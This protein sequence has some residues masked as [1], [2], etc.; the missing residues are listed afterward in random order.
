MAHVGFVL[1]RDDPYAIIDLD[2]P[3]NP[4]QEKRHN[5]ILECCETYCEFSQS[6]QGVHIICKGAIPH[7]VRRDKVEVYSDQRYMICT[8]NVFRSMPITDHQP[9]LDALYRQMA[10][11]GRVTLTDTPETMADNDITTMA[12]RA[13]NGDKFT[14]LW[15]GDFASYP[16]QSEADFAL[17]SMIAFYS[18]SNEQCRR[19]FRDS[20]LGKRD[21]AQRDKYLDYMLTK[22][23]AHEPAEVDLTDLIRTTE[24]KLQLTI[25]QPNAH[26]SAPVRDHTPVTT[27]TP[28]PPALPA[29]R[30]VFP[31]GL[32]GEISGYFTESAIRPVAEI[33][34]ASALA[35]G[36]GVAG[37]SYNISG[38]GLNQYLILLAR[39]GSGKEGAANGIDALVAAARRIVPMADRF[40]GPATFASG[41]ALVRVLDDRPCFVSV[42]GEFGVT[43]QQL[44]DPRAPAP[45]AMLKRV[46]LDLYGKSGFTKVLRSS[47][48]SDTEKN[49]KTIQAP[50]VTILGESVPEKF[51]DGLDTSHILEGLVPRFCVIEYT[52]P[53]PDRNK[54][55]NGAPPEE[56]VERFVE[57][58]TIGL[59]T[60]Q[61]STC[62][63]VSIDPDALSLLDDFDEH[64]TKQINDSP[65]E[66][67]RQLWNRAH[68]KALKLAG[69]VAV[70]CD[71]QNPVV[72]KRIAEWAL[73][74]VHNDVTRL[75]AKFASGDVGEGES[76][77]ESDLRRAITTY[78]TLTPEERETYRV[79]AAL[80]GQPVVPFH[81]LRRR[82]RLLASFR[83][84]KRGVNGALQSLL[85]AMVRDSSLGHLPLNQARTQYGVEQPLYT[86][87]ET[88]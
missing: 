66:A 46:L 10:S 58:L 71:M 41:Q 75:L 36:A 19:L 1:H 74:F 13:V 34:L 11:T 57:L 61:N 67:H 30:V 60:Q 52:G 25:H 50:N 65:G 84:D 26:L 63:P 76:K 70:G 5:D 53:R 82:V 85:D 72:T 42:L 6:G 22:I 4:E 9:L 29:R 24:N 62:M 14:S 38:T 73:A 3:L 51:Y 86:L 83:N 88:W 69:L 18:K 16:S 49:T 15:T 7:G 8:G 2:A 47:V 44:C 54:S 81:Y 59:T 27:T 35:V 77:Q 20:E 68:L 39:T 87:G 28:K 80:V 79:P 45:T 17:M 64:A 43:L 55:A 12:S 78:F 37:R 21:K 31:P 48:Y 23:R 32:I 33:A 40:I 56:L